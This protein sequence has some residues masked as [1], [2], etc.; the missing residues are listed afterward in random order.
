MGKQLFLGLPQRGNSLCRNLFLE[1]LVAAKGLVPKGKFFADSLSPPF[2]P[3][4][5]FQRIP[6][7]QKN[8][9]FHGILVQTEWQHAALVLPCAERE[10]MAV[11]G[12]RSETEPSPALV[13]LLLLTSLR[14]SFLL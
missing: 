4:E 7:P 10:R 2:L 12:G 5:Q 14:L 3:Y 6:P 13:Y 8:L 11:K 1:P 9:H